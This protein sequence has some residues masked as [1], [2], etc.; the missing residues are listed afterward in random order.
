M[1]TAGRRTI[2]VVDNDPVVVSALTTRLSV[3]GYACSIARCGSEAL[4]RFQECPHDLVVSDLH[5]PRGDGVTLAE[6]IRRL[7]DVPIILMS[8]VKDDFRRRLRT[9]RDVSFLHKP[10]ETRTLLDV[11]AA[12]IRSNGLS[13]S[14]MSTENYRG[15]R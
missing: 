9:L 7:S 5:M 8:G 3:N 14:P 15:V 12:T 13:A 2:L 4:T 1:S 11:V 6:S 10:F